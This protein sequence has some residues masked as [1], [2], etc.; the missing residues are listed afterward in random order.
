LGGGVGIGLGGFGARDTIVN[1]IT[2]DQIACPEQVIWYV[3]V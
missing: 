2:F 3:V 1:R